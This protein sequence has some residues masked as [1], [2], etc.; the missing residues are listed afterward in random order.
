MRLSN[1]QNSTV[2]SKNVIKNGFVL[3]LT[4]VLLLGLSFKSNAGNSGDNSSEASYSSLLSEAV[5][6]YHA[7]NIVRAEKLFFRAKAMNPQQPAPYHHLASIQEHK[8][9]TPLFF[10]NFEMNPKQVKEISARYETMISLISMNGSE[11]EFYPELKLNHL[12]G[13][14]ALSYNVRGKS[15]SA[16]WALEEGKNRGAFTSSSLEY[17]RNILASADENAIIVGR[18]SDTYSLYYLQMI[19]GLRKDVT[20]IDYNMMSSV[21]YIEDFLQQ[22]N[23]ATAKC[24]SI[25]LQRSKQL[26]NYN[27]DTFRSRDLTLAMNNGEQIQWT[28]KP[29]SFGFRLHQRDYMLLNLIAENSGN[30]PFYFL[31]NNFNEKNVLW[32]DEYISNEG[33]LY[34]LVSSKDKSGIN[35]ASILNLFNNEWNMDDALSSDENLSLHDYYYSSYLIPVMKSIESE[36][37]A[38]QHSKARTLFTQLNE[39]MNPA[40][41]PYPEYLMKPYKNINSELSTA[42]K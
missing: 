14:L 42:R 39:R 15:D 2:F 3:S 38:D 27:L 10:Q 21:T 32:L 29:T 4:A 9:F 31:M 28:L 20:V 8:I 25:Q 22:Q 16:A 11:K 35:S 34:K 19:E 1:Y 5:D 17:G 40:K 18:I 37:A 6:I 7:G 12:W 24:R 36:L 13:S 23:G 33:L 30:R 41:H 26:K